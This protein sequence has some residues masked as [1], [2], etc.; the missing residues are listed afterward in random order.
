MRWPR[1]EFVAALLAAGVT[2]AGPVR[3]AAPTLDSLSDAPDPAH[4][5]SADR[6]GDA[7]AYADL[8]R[9]WRRAE[10]INAWIGAHFEY[11]RERALALSESARAARAQRVAILEPEAFYA[12]PRGVCVDLSRFA[13]STLRRV[14]PDAQASYLM[15]EF[16]PVQVQGQWL[17]RHWMAAFR[18]D[19]AWWFFADSKR[20]GYLAGPYDTPERFLADYAAYRDRTILSHRVLP[21]YERQPRSR[22]AR[23]L[24]AEPG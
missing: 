6:S 20:P 3:A 1:R 9:H 2:L 23:T 15:I 7:L 5:R 12:A 13:V 11:D 22:A 14:E 18:R 8:P 21:S 19:G 10:D 16:E 24:R 4:R 17:R